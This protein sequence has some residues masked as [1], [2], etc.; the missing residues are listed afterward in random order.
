MMQL[1]PTSCGTEYLDIFIT[2]LFRIYRTWYVAC[3]LFL[4]VKIKVV[5]DEFQVKIL[6]KH[7]LV[8]TTELRAS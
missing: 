7:F 2:N 3:P 1:A 6:R 4:L 8:V 5:R